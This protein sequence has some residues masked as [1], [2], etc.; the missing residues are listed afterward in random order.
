MALMAKMTSLRGDLLGRNTS[1]T[2]GR[3]T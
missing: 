2:A 3:G 1:T